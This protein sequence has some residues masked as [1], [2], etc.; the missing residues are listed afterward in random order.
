MGGQIT[1]SIFEKYKIMKPVLIL[2]WNPMG[3]CGESKGKNK[4]GEIK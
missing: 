3:L 4:N 2:I 1:K